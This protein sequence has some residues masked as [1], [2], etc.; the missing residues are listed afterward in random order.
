[1]FAFD[2]LI[3]CV[4]VCARCV[5]TNLSGQWRSSLLMKESFKLNDITIARAS[6]RSLSDDEL[7]SFPMRHD[8]NRKVI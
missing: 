7:K 1:M 4:G 3:L 2:S 5:I 8:G 6:A